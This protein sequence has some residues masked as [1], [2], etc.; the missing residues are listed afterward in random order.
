MTHLEQYK[1]F[2]DAAGV[3]YSEDP[4]AFGPS[5]DECVEI[6]VEEVGFSTPLRWSGYSGF[7]FSFT[8]DR[9]TGVVV[10]VGASEG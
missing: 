4:R 5:D 3:P 6:S 2:L 7:G 10:A 8:F 9:D 1:A